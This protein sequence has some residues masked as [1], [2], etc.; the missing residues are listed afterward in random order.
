[1]KPMTEAEFWIA[2]RRASS[3]AIAWKAAGAML[4]GLLTGLVAAW[5]WSIVEIYNVFF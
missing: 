1:M 2:H 5:M 3:Q 4:L